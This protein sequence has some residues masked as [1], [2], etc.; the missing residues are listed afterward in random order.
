ME[1][2]GRGIA[3]WA[4][5]VALLGFNGWTEATRDPA[6][7]AVDAAWIASQGQAEA[8]ARAA[9]ALVAVRAKNALRGESGSGVIVAPCPGAG[10]RLASACTRRSFC[11]RISPRCER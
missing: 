11:S 10:S 4:V 6:G 7:V 1:S 9:P 5:L 2:R 3:T 8:V